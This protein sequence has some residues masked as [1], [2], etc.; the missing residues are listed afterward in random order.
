LYS[1]NRNTNAYDQVVTGGSA[2]AATLSEAQTNSSLQIQ[3]I[4]LN[5]NL[6]TGR[7]NVNAFVAFE[8]SQNRSET[9]VHQD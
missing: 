1:Y 9:L 4:K 3:N 6:A 8:Q 2:G 7:H 5:Y